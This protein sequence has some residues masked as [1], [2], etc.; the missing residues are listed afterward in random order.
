MANLDH[1]LVRTPEEA[2]EL[3]AKEV[4]PSSVPKRTLNEKKDAVGRTW[5]KIFCANCGKPDGWV[6][7]DWAYYVSSLCDQCVFTHGHPPLSPFTEED[8]R[9]ARRGDPVPTRFSGV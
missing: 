4:Q 6:T 9:A 8:T 1:H 2:W 7:K 3:Y 5:V